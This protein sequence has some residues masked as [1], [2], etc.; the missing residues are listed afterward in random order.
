M[1]ACL[2]CN[3]VGS[4]AEL[5]GGALVDDDLVVAYHLPPIDRFPRQYLG[6]VLLV[7]RRH[8]DHLGDLTDE[9]AAA[10]GRGSRVVAA[11]MRRLD[12]VTRVHVAVIGLHV[13]HFHLH[14]IARYAWVPPDADW[15]ALHELPQA[16]LGAAEE[17]AEFAER[18]RRRLD[19]TLS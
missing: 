14:L 3:Q 18:L 4:I 5:P 1:S 11:G 16:P 2:I 8:V 13:R 15:N 12:D 6:R 9:E 17:I 7:T 10:V 19:P